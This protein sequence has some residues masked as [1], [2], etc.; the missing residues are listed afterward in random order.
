MPRT[1]RILK[2]LLP[3]MLPT[4]ISALPRS[5]AF[6]LVG[7][8][9]RKTGS[10]RHDGKTDHPVADTDVFGDDCSAVYGYVTA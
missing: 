10:E 6:V 2:I 5:A 3:T 1:K 7:A 8:S 4:A 9:V